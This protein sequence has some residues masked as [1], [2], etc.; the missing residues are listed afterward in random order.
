MTYNQFS[1][2]PPRRFASLKPRRIF[3]AKYS[4]KFTQLE[5]FYV[6]NRYSSNPFR[7]TKSSSTF[8][9]FP[10]CVPLNGAKKRFHLVPRRER[11]SKFSSRTEKFNKFISKQIKLC[12]CKILEQKVFLKTHVEPQIGECCCFSRAKESKSTDN[13]T[14]KTNWKISFFFVTI[15][16]SQMTSARKLRVQPTTVQSA[17]P[18]PSALKVNSP[19]K[20]WLILCVS[21]GFLK[22]CLNV[23]VKVNTNIY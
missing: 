21:S 22:F 19:Y 17:P 20:F 7:C 1:F 5:I 13:N 9:G 12:R 6:W 4:F 3:Q 14:N 11:Q 23:F 18:P 16:R 15:R 2:N 8:Y 10:V